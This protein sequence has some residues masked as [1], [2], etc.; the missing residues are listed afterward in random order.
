[1]KKANKEF[2]CNLLKAEGP[3]SSEGEAS[4]VWMDEAKPF[5]DEVGE[6]IMG[7]VRAHLAFPSGSS[8]KHAPKVLLTAHIDEIG[9][10]ISHIDSD[11]Y[12]SFTSIGGWD[13]QI[14]QGQRV[15]IS[16][17][18]GKVQGVIGKQAIHLMSASDRK[19]VPQ[20]KDLW[21]DI[22]ASNK[23]KAEAKVS[24]GDTGVLQVSPVE[25]MGN[26]I[27]SKALDNRAGAYVVLQAM[28]KLSEMD[29]QPPVNVYGLM[30]VQ[31]EVDLR[32]IVT[33]T[34]GIKPDVGI[35]VDV[36]FS[37]DYPGGDPKRGEIK[38]GSG[39]VVSTGTVT[40]PSL[41]KHVMKTAKEQ[42][43]SVQIEACSGWSGTDTNNLQ[44]SRG[45]IATILVSIP[46]R[47]MHTP[48]ETVDLSDL[49]KAA[50]LL[51]E[52]VATI[53]VD[54]D[55]VKKVRNTIKG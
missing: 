17:S 42:D 2:L 22:G 24:V 35:V 31:E 39:P 37:S 5:C 40:A 21:I 6:D 29:P 15:S 14:L 43:I 18:E 54:S 34:Y 48:C 3:S 1:M 52:S 30:S 26:K 25:L 41:F 55:F 32:G 49:D 23:K 16:T 47:Y 10:M 13:T 53:T 50:E 45:G 4:K 33:G 51:A 12:L 20:I 9:F 36:T 38:L 19:D 11:G 7:N 8:K 27:S 44:L 46:L 28:K